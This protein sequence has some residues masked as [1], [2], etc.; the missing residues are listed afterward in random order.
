MKEKITYLKKTWK[1][2]KK[3]K[4]IFTLYTIVGLI[5]SI[6]MAVV[7]ILSAKLITG[8]TNNIMEQV[9][10]FAIIIA[11]T[12]IVSYVF[13]LFMDMFYF[14]ITGKIVFDIRKDVTSSILNLETKNF[15]EKSSGI[16]VKRIDEDPFEMAWI[17]NSLRMTITNIF[18][19]I[20]VFIL[21]FI[22]NIY[23]GIFF[24]ISIIIIYYIQKARILYRNSSWKEYKEIKDQ[25][26]GIFQE[27]LRGVRDIKV[28]GLKKQ[29]MTHVLN[30]LNKSYEKRNIIDIK[31][32]L[33]WEIDYAVKSVMKFL[34]VLLGIILVRLDILI[35]TNFLVLYMYQERVFKLIQYISE[36]AGDYKDFEVA[37]KRIFEITENSTFKKEEFGNIKINKLKGNIEFKNIVFGY[38]DKKIINN[39]NLKINSNDTVAIVGKS[40]QG[41]ST[42]FSLLSKLYNVDSG[43]ILIDN[44]SIYKI[45]ESTLRK[46]ISVITQVPYI[47]NMSIKDNL[48]LVNRNI[49]NKE[50][51]EKCKL[52]SLHNYIMTLPNK[53]D[54]IIGEGGINLSGGQRQRLA[55]ARALVKNSKIIL[56]D[57]ATSALD[58]ETQKEIQNSIRNISKE[59]TILI[60]AHRLSTITFCNKIVVIDKGK[61][62]GIGTH[63]ELIK[64]NKIYKG[65][66]KGS[67][68]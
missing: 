64:T 34:F 20:G 44:K 2:F 4:K 11:A 10:I 56:F 50:I 22:I 51:I 52:A 46:N 6:L 60:I 1:Y 24:T 35:V 28:L 59:Y 49:T 3:Y 57:E 55:I 58:N 45:D 68:E 27:I 32:S 62:N 48:K 54:T 8:I 40:G 30:S 37:A 26:A 36:L 41:K 12:E 17:F 65:L 19:N 66:Y 33:Y 9:F 38:D 39:F 14:K 47:F 23:V 7:P 21:I 29:F 31:N 15:D 43:D 16:F 5:Y 61:V 67:L 18:T 53:Y 42:I 63:D 13:E 25:N